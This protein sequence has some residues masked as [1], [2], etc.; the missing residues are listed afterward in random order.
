[1]TFNITVYNQ[2]TLDAYD[3]EVNDYTPA[4]FILCDPSWID[5]GGTASL[6]NE[7]PF[8]AAG[9]DETVTI[10]FTVDPAFQGTSITVS[11][12]HL[13]LPTIYSV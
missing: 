7:I 6:L 10:T 11:D 1:M 12:T 5:N 3:I 4:G 8:I 9:D 2:G 13:T